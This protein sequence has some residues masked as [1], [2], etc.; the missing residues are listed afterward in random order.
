[1][2]QQVDWTEENGIEMKRSPRNVRELIKI[3]QTQ[4][5]D[6]A[7][8]VRTLLEEIL[9][10]ICHGLG[11]Q[12]SFRFNDRNE[13][14]MVGELLSNLRGTLKRKS[15]ALSS[16]QIFN[17]I[18]TSNL[19]G[20]MGSHDNPKETSEGDITVALEDIDNFEKLFRCGGTCR[21]FLSSES[22]SQADKKLSCKC[23]TLTIPWT[24]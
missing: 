7:N 22:F 4:G 20:T 17:Q 6:V 10:D 21:E 18:E 19:L 14:R 12:L 24:D 5:H 1:M 3:K 16:D 13:E 23:G 15:P 2:L 8:D 9:K 11:V